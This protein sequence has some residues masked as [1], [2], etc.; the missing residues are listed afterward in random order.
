MSYSPPKANPQSD[1]LQIAYI[2]LWADPADNTRVLIRD[3]RFG[4]MG[5]FKSEELAA[6]IQAYF[7]KQ[8]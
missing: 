7:W 2:E 4:E 1:K 5:K 8:F 3:R 6:V